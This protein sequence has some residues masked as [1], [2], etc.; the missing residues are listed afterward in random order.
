[1]SSQLKAGKY[2]KPTKPRRVSY[3]DHFPHS[4]LSPYSPSQGSPTPEIIQRRIN[5]KCCV[6]LSRPGVATSEF[7]GTIHGNVEIIKD[8]TDLLQ[9]DLIDSF[10]SHR[11]NRFC[12]ALRK[13]D[14]KSDN[15]VK[16]DQQRPIRKMLMTLF[17]PEA[18][19]CKN[20]DSLIKVGSAMY[21]LGIHIKVAQHILGNP[22]NYA[23]QLQLDDPITARFKAN[24]N[25]DSLIE[26]LAT[27]P[28]ATSD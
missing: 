12:S 3:F 15:Y 8:A 16:R 4:F 6:W 28:D 11:T 1:M 7:A 17:D 18:D 5:P 20:V 14:C 26:Y 10:T 23:A 9:P 24:P 2:V 22:V 21:V 13:L 19:P 25:L 27:M